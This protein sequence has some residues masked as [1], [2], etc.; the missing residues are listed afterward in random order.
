MQAALDAVRSNTLSIRKTSQRFNIPK[1][2]LLRRLHNVVEHPEPRNDTY[3]QV[4]TAE[5]EKVLLNHILDL[6][7][8]FYGITATECRKLAF[9][10]AESLNIKHP[11][12]KDVKLAG[13]DWFTGFRKRNPQFSIRAPE[14]TSVARAVGFNRPQV[15]RFFSLIDS[16]LRKHN[17][18]AHQIFNIDECGF[19]TVPVPRKILAQKGKKQVGRIVSAERGFNTTAV[20]GI[21]AS[22]FY[23]PP[24]FL[25]ARQRMNPLLMKGCSAGSQGY[26]NSSGWMDGD[27]FL[28]FL[29]HF[30]NVVKPSE[31]RKILLVLDNHGS[32]WTLEAITKAKANHIILISL[33]PHTSHRLQPLDCCIYGPL[34]AQ[35]ARECDV[36][37]TNHPGQRLSIYEVVE[38][39]S[40]AFARIA[41]VE[42]AVKGFSVTGIWPFNP[43]VFND[44]D[45]LPSEMTHVEEMVDDLQ[46]QEKE[47]Q[48]KVTEQP[49]HDR[50][51]R[52]D[53][54]QSFAECIELLSPKP[55]TSKKR[56]ASKRKTQ[57]SEELTSTPFKDELE[58]IIAAKENPKTKVKRKLSDESHATQK[59]GK[60]KQQ[61][62]NTKKRQVS[63][64][65]EDDQQN[66]ECLY[67]NSSF[68]QSKSGEG[69]I[70][71]L[72]CK[73]WAHD[74]CAGVEDDED[75]FQCNL[76]INK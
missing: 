41:S 30:I 56:Q 23:I 26:A 32:H 14:P 22:G 73:Q 33:P 20:C 68:L 65:S 21:S 67:C 44:Q 53:E 62:K 74:A 10:L 34:K 63:S 13:Y 18:Q 72:L 1:T 15:E 16:T 51:D 19:N 66:T 12:N 2:C 58:K 8:R 70:Q 17:L 42:K 48:N 24:F 11:F 71:C 4:F 49:I 55:S 9:D 27:H 52:V 76:C 50:E 64:E 54:T 75:V 57:R 47:N 37:M 29:D 60:G 45:F 40:T 28:K 5:Q 59:K 39:F 69:W 43:T 61:M 7:S 36:W 6:E 25:F 46:P 35:Y 31:D 3:K 38:I